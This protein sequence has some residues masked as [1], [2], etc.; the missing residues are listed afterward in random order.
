MIVHWGG[1]PSGETVGLKKVMKIKFRRYLLLP[2]TAMLFACAG[3]FSLD[4]ADMKDVHG[5]TLSLHEHGGQPKEHIVVSN[6]GWYL[7]NRFPLVCGNAKKDAFFPWAFFYNDV[8]ET[9]IQNRLTG[10]AAEH[11]C[12]VVDINMFN[13]EQVL[14]NIYNIPVPIPY[15]CCYREMQI[16]AILVKRPDE[17]DAAAQRQIEMKREMKDLLDRIPGEDSK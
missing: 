3:C 8:D 17:E 7:F 13:N 5:S 11:S 2:C 15:I 4:I 16:S 9:V 10:Y 14:L 12:D 1:E 6:Y